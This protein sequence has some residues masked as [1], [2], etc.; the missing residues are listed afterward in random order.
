MKH[1]NK[2]VLGI[3]FLQ[4]VVSLIILFVIWGV[5]NKKID[6]DSSVEKAVSKYASNFTPAFIKG[7]KGEQGIKGEK[8]D[9]GR[10]GQQGPV[11]QPGPQGF[12]GL[13]GIQ[14]EKGD[15]GDK[16][17]TGE[18][19]VPGEPGQPGRSP[20]FRCNQESANFE[21]RYVGDED[22]QKTGGKCIPGGE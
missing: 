22:W 21:W 7:E 19:G 12:Q 2:I 14:G 9:D 4:A 16:G 17:D 5:V 10:D 6:I 13:M 1:T 3:V 20:E 18:Q 8:G 11:G 15:K